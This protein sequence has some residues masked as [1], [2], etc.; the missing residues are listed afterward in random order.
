MKFETMD[1]AH[2]RAL[3]ADAFEA[4][5]AALI[6]AL[7]DPECEVTTDALLAE[8]DIVT[9]EVERRSAAVQLRNAKVAAVADGAG[10][11]VERSADTKQRHTIVSG[12]GDDPYDTPE[13]NRAFYEYVTRGV[14]TPGIINPDVKPSY[15]RAD[16]FTTVATDVPNYVPTHLMNEIIEKAESYGELYPLF[17]KTNLQG[18]VEYPV[19][20]FDVKA[21]WVTEDKASDDQ[22]LVDAENIKFSY[23]MLECKLAQSILSSVA[24]L[25]AF[26]AK[27]PELAYRAVVKKLEEGFISGTGSGQ[28]T[29]VTVDTRIPAENKLSLKAEDIS[30]WQGWVG[31]VKAKM[32]KEYRDGIF[33]MNQATFDKYVDGMVDA[34][35][36]PVARVTYGID[37]GET[38]RFMGKSVITV[39]DALL[40]SFDDAA[41]D[42]AFA[43]FTRPQDYVINSN[44]AMRAVRWVDEDSNLVKN[45]CQTIVDGKL[46]RPWGTLVLTKANGD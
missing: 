7:N 39:G 13:Y 33:I 3:D 44:L 32:K 43:V 36:Q 1:A 35:G 17:T 23:Y 21:E 46:L 8:K 20:E 22:K 26:Q 27:F 4:R 9:K 14:R 28:M 34:N 6:D 18:G 30:T 45:K 11:V 25:S 37:G 5:K 12:D 10:K 24:T 42:K 40:P 41:A 31:N 15:V 29:G 2:Y 38:Y 19:G 16:Q